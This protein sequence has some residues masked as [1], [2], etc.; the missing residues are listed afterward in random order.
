MLMV[1]FASGSDIFEPLD[2]FSS[3]GSGRGGGARDC[4][5]LYNPLISLNINTS[6]R[7]TNHLTTYHIQSS[8][9]SNVLTLRRYSESIICIDINLLCTYVTDEK[10][11]RHLPVVAILNTLAFPWRGSIRRILSS[12]IM[13]PI[14]G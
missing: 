2:G 7:S 4:I 6:S 14:S 9:S 10:C 8:R 13:P 5:A 1:T 12:G 3:S 11:E